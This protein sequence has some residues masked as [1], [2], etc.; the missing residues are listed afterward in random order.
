MSHNHCSLL[1]HPT[2]AGSMIASQC[3]PS[4]QQVALQLGLV[5]VALAKTACAVDCQFG[6]RLTADR[7]WRP[8]PNSLSAC[9]PTCRPCCWRREEGWRR[10]E[11]AHAVLS[12]AACA[13]EMEKA[14]VRF[15]T[16]VDH[17]A[18]AEKAKVACARVPGLTPGMC[19]KV[20]AEATR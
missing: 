19:D 3:V 9:R 13:G 7:S 11:A 12:N 20:H 10:T 1:A 6:E 18:F 2:P 4:F 16:D 17:K 8:A 5:D 15:M 14:G